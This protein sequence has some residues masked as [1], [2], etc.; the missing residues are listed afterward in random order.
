VPSNFIPSLLVLV[1]GNTEAILLP[2]FL[3]LS[4]SKP[5]DPSIT[6]VSCGG[7]KQVLR[8]YLQMRDLTRLP[9]L[10]VIDKD[11]T[12]QIETIEQVLRS[13]DRLHIWNAGEIE[14]TF[15]QESILDNLNIYLQSLGASELLLTEDL[16]SGNRRTELLNRL[17]RNR[18]LG[19]FDKVGFAEFML[20]RLRSSNDVP[21]EG[22][23]LMNLIK[24]MAQGKHAGT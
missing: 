9:I 7:A 18:G 24:N 16:Q 6:F 17:W 10:C 12:E 14:D 22:K 8:K 19:D 5:G 15:T 1:E 2:R 13:N 4:G 11:A 23:E 3:A 21:P 20:T